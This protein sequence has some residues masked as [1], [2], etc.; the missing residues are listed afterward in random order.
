MRPGNVEPGGLNGDAASKGSD[1]R[2][3]A[4]AIESCARETL[5]Q[6]RKLEMLEMEDRRSVG[7]RFVVMG[8]G[9]VVKTDDGFHDRG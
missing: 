7:P 3:G 4:R 9:T 5:S 8:V 6:A 2:D 1:T